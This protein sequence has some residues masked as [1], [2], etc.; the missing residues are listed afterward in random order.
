MNLATISIDGQATVAVI[1]AVKKQA[2]LVDGA[3]DMLDL[4]D[5]WENL[6]GGLTASGRVIP[7]ADVRLL[8][9]IPHPRRNLFCVG[10]NYREH[11]HEFAKSGFDSSVGNNGDAIPDYPI[12]FSKVPDCVI[13][14]GEPVRYPTGVSVC[15]DYEAELAVIVGKGGRAIRREAAMEHVFGFAV[16]NDITARDLQIRH[17]QWLIGKSLDTFGPFGPWIV[18]ADSVVSNNLDVKCWVNNELR[19][20][21]NTR[22]LIFDI[23]TLI[24]TISA[25]ITLRPGDI[26][27]TGTP[28]G[29]GIGFTPPKYLVPGDHV[30]VDIENIG[31]L[32][33]T[34]I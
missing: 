26:I 13:A 12:I 2:R 23:P 15:V 4:I 14:N 31:R 32:E 9:P 34:V 18:T 20:S 29:V 19:Q 10:K 5:R 8:P 1:D 30:V 17:K 6:K 7:L 3:T 25:G 21:S 33:N 16:F 11:A 27:A 24:E 22:D 28:A